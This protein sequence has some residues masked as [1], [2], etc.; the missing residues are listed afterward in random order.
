MRGHGAA[1]GAGVGNQHDI[2]FAAARQV[3][4]AAKHVAGF[5]QGAD[6]RGHLRR[7]FVDP[8]QVDDRVPG[9]VQ[10]WPDERVHAR[11]Q[12]DVSG[13]TFPF[14]LGHPA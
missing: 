12:T 4:V 13:F 8:A 7:F 2:A 5:A 3:A 6:H 14:Y 9:P 1:I 10:R 11:I